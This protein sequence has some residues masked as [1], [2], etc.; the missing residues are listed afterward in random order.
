MPPS[1]D[2]PVTPL[3]KFGEFL[4]QRFRDA[5]VQKH[6]LLQQGH[7][8]APALQ[9]LQGEINKLP[10]ATKSLLLR[11]V[12]DAVDTGIHDFLLAL[13]ESHDLGS[14]IEVIV[15]DHNVAATSDGLHGELFGE[16]GW[17]ARFSQRPED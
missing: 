11:C 17:Y 1:N 15:D 7:W 8:K 4:M 12:V 16:R 5:A 9:S 3:D 6:V 10:E 14:G 2:V 13:Q